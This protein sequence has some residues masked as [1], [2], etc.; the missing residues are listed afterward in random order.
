[1]AVPE[2]TGRAVF[3]GGA[4][5]E[6]SADA[7]IPVGSE[8]ADTDPFLFEAVTMRRIVDPASAD[9]RPYVAPEASGIVVQ[10]PPVVLQRLHW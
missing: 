4:G 1:V 8:V 7:T 5:D 3:A 9:A 6:V 2:I 10:L